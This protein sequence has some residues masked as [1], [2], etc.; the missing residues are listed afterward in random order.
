M[1]DQNTGWIGEAVY[2]AWQVTAEVVGLAKVV[3]AGEAVIS[4]EAGRAKL[5]GHLLSELADHRRLYPRQVLSAK[6][7]DRQKGVT[8]VRAVG[9]R[10]AE[11][12]LD[13]GFSHC[14]GLVNVQVSVD[15]VRLAAELGL[16]EVILRGNFLDELFRPNFASRWHGAAEAI[17]I[18]L[19]QQWRRA[20]AGRKTEVFVGKAQVQT[21]IEVV[22]K[23]E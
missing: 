1:D 5:S 9:L 4:A 16:E 22:S 7:F 11:N 14:R 18:G 17:A 3:D 10:Q 12:K 19:E 2:N 20:F 6:C 13:E 15:I 23:G 8:D 21:D